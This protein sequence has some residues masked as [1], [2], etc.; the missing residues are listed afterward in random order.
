MKLY[1]YIIKNITSESPL[2]KFLLLYHHRKIESDRGYQK[3]K[4]RIHEL[5]VLWQKEK[6]HST[7]S[8]YIETF[9]IN[10]ITSVYFTNSHF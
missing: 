10:T 8:K 5:K 1:R 3:N 2:Y 6:L 7:I 4:E 9:D